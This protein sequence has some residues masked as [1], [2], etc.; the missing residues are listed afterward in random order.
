[1]L[2]VLALMGCTQKQTTVTIKTPAQRVAVYNG[3]L[4][5]LNKAATEGVIGLQKSGVLTV[6]QT[7]LVLGYTLKVATAS[8]A[9]ATIQ[10]NP[11]DWTATAKQI[12]TILGQIPLPAEVSKLISGP[13]AAQVLSIFTSIQTYIQQMLKEVAQ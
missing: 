10:Q 1:V 7:S 12:Q 11:G 9:V 4:A 2:L 8:K 13:Q 6:A 3:T 5:E